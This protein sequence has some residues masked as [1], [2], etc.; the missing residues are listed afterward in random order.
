MHKKPLKGLYHAHS[1]FSYDGQKYFKDIVDWSKK[2]TFDFVILTEHDYG[3]TEEKF[4]KYVAQCRVNREIIFIPG[5]EY[6]FKCNK[7]PIHISVFGMDEFIDLKQRQMGIPDFLEYV[8]KIGGVSVLNHSFRVI[9]ELDCK[10]FEL[11]DFIEMWNLVYDIKYAPKIKI[12]EYSR[13]KKFNGKYLA[14]SD[15][16]KWLNKNKYPYVK[17][18]Q[19]DTCRTEKGIIKSL[20]DGDYKIISR[21]WRIHPNGVCVPSSN[22]FKILPKISLAHQVF[23]ETLRN[24]YYRNFKVAPPKWLVKMIK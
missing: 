22:F 4:E 8:H 14:S 9:E 16:H 19:N 15:V 13:N 11:F 1:I 5:I 12:I 23:Y 10:C 18:Y 3:F 17:V 6:S 7:G 2:E 20:K 24:N 21:F